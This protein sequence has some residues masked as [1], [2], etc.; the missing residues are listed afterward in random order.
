[1][2]KCYKCDLEGT[3][4]EIDSY[5]GKPP[6]KFCLC[7]KHAQKMGFCLGCGYFLSGVEYYE[8]SA[9]YSYGYCQPC[10]TA[11]ND[12]ISDYQEEDDYYF[13]N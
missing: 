8:F 2:T 12:E 6:D 10:W 4:W 11:L 3:V 13:I 7:E 1:M 5:D 9:G